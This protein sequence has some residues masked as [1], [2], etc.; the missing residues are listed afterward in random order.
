MSTIN[1][2]SNI[3][4]KPKFF[5]GFLALLASIGLIAFSLFVAFTEYT[6]KKVRLVNTSKMG[7][8]TITINDKIETASFLLSPNGTGNYSPWV[9]TGIELTKGDKIS[10]SVSGK[11]CLG[12]HRMVHAANVDSLPTLPWN[13][14]KGVDEEYYKPPRNK[15]EKETN[16][17]KF[18]IAPK[19]PHEKMLGVITYKNPPGILVSKDIINISSSNKKSLY[20]VKE[21]GKL[22]LTVNDVW[23]SKGLLDTVDKDAI[24]LEQEEIDY[25]IQNKYWNIWYDDNAGFFSVIIEVENNN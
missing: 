14:Y 1:L 21:N 18:L 9:N 13:G 8:L 20:E 3:F 10:F 23:L 5:F 7:A 16:R 11:V 6:T 25:I 24:M 15:V 12:F 2:I 4:T 17:S 22:W 19:Y